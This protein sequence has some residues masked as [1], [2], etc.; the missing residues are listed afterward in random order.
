MH[1]YLIRITKLPSRQ[2]DVL[3]ADETA[4]RSRYSILSEK[5]FPI[6]TPTSTFLCSLSAGIGGEGNL[7]NI[8][9]CWHLLF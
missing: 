5:L 3:L 8:E 4:F 6:S 7:S 9:T 2:F 1:I